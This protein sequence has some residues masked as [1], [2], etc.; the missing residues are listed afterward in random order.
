[1]YGAIDDDVFKLPGLQHG[2]RAVF[3]G[4]SSPGHDVAVNGQYVGSPFFVER[5]QSPDG[6]VVWANP[7]FQSWIDRVMSS[8]K[9]HAGM[10]KGKPGIK[11][12]ALLPNT[13]EP[14]D[15]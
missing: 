4:L 14:K 2:Q 9:L 7:D 13:P 1:M 5:I 12:P 6:K 11:L 15:P 10:L 8:P 3:I